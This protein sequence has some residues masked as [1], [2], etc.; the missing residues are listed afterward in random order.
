MDSEHKL[1]LLLGHPQNG[2]GQEERSFLVLSGMMGVGVQQHLG[3]HRFLIPDLAIACFMTALGIVK[4]F[5]ILKIVVF[6]FKGSYFLCKD[7]VM[8]MF[9]DML[10]VKVGLFS[11]FSC[12]CRTMQN[13]FAYIGMV[14]VF[15]FPVTEFDPD[16][17]FS[18]FFSF[19]ILT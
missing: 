19:L 8:Y 17:E 1:A 6:I 18:H 3:G 12:Y 5:R 14:C 16:A 11:L 2:R 10:A 15:L 13:I 9:S 7:K 4:Q